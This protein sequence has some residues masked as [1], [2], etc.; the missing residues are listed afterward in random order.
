MGL[1]ERQV[2]IIGLL[3]MDIVYDIEMKTQLDSGV[4]CQLL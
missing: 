2:C 4:M 3:T 1:T